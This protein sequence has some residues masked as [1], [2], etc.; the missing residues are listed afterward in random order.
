MNVLNF[1]NCIKKG[2]YKLHSKFRNVHNYTKDREIISLVSAKIGRGPN[3]VVLNNL[4]IFAQQTVIIS[5]TSLSIGNAILQINKVKTKFIKDIFIKDI[6]S[7]LS[8]IEILSDFISDKM[9]P[10]SLGSLL[11]SP[12]ESYLQTTFEKAFLTHAKQ[13]VQ[14]ISLEKLPAITKKMKGLGFGLTPSGDDFNCGILY[15]LNYLNEIGNGNYSEIIEECYSNSIGNN[16]ISNAFLKYAY[17]NQFYENF[18]KLLK[19][20]K[21]N[22]QNTI[23]HCAK[24]VINSGHTSGADMLT[25]FILT[26]KG[27]LN[28]K[29]LS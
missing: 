3:N 18:Y 20:L 29:K 10:K 11:F 5:N 21:Q 28:D 4:P 12:N 9:S 22:K 24:K 6:T 1:G 13:A 19:A 14:D 8:G 27:G 7:L 16:L 2:K 23:S 17:L 15:A 25:G 26:L